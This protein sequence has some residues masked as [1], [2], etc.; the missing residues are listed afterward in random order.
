MR[1]LLSGSNACALVLRRL[2]L[3]CAGRRLSGF[4]ADAPF[5]WPCQREK[6]P[7]IAAQINAVLPAGV[8]LY[9]I[10]PDYQPALFY[11]RDPIVYLAR[12]A[13]A[14]GDARFLLV[15]P[16]DASGSA[17]ARS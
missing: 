1:F 12:V 14:P 9:A 3:V 6:G 16:A 11:V 5:P 10:D 15:Q 13:D 4:A 2:A 8:P 7:K 17:G